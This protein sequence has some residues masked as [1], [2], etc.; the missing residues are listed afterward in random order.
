MSKKEIILSE[1]STKMIP[2]AIGADVYYAVNDFSVQQEHR[3][4]QEIYDYAKEFEPWQIESARLRSH[5][6]TFASIAKTLG[7]SR[8]DIS[9][10]LKE[11][12]LDK[13]FNF[14]IHLRIYQDGPNEQLR[15]NMLWRIA[16][17]NEKKDPKESRG[18]LAEL[19]RMSQG[20]RGSGGFNI[21]INGVEL[22]KGP[23]DA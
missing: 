7:K 5:G 3:L 8:Q 1:A 21:V 18:A 17:D 12:A 19:N 14:F 22:K 11:P 23:L 4:K 9:N 6:E 15:R 20:H 10:A 13:L 2:E 16:V